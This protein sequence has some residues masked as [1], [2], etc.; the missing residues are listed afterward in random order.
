MDVALGTVYTGV[1]ST[2]DTLW[3]E[4]DTAGQA[5]H[6]RFWRMPLDEAYGPQIYSSNADLCNTGGKSA[7][8]CTAALFLKAF[9][10]GIPSEDGE[11]EG[12]VRW[13]HVDMAGTMESP[14]G[15][16][17]QEKGMTGRPVR[18]FVEFARRLS[19]GN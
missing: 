10:K 17:Y 19:E 15:E 11:G 7:G 8:S 5:E 13:A 6:D 2:S 3:N 12:T 18:A 16:P 1:F 14:R 9:V 4:L